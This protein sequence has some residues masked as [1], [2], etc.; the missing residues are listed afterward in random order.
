MPHAAA[1]RKQPEML[2]ENLAE[3]LTEKNWQK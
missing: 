1:V 3:K 2:T